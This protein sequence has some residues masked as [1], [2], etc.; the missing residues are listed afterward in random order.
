MKGLKENVSLSPFT[1]FKIGGKARYFFSAKN[2]EDIIKAVKTATA[3]KMP[4][5]VLGGGSN[6]LV[7]DKGFNG[8]VIHIENK[9]YSINDNKLYAEAGV[10]FP[11]LVSKT[12]SK[13][14]SGLEWAGGLPGTIGGAIRGNAGAFGGE[15]KDS[16]I[17]VEVLDNKR[18]VMKLKNKECKFSYRSSIFKEKNWI[19]I[20][21]VF[22]LKKGNKERILKE[23]KEHIKYRKDRHPLEYPN[24]GSIF[25]NYDAK[26]IPNRY[27]KELQHVIKRDPFDVIPTAYLIS[28][29]DLKGSRW[30]DAEVSKKHPNYIVNK[31]KAKAKDVKA[32]ISKVKKKIKEKY[33]IDL[34]QEVTI[35]E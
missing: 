27:R 17:E 22:K 23:A 21:A 33:S 24:A 4:F 6:L 29:A 16:V 30:H 1:T 19:V 11:V 15:I 31:G 28:Q 8:L 35:L 3:L 2:K 9:G 26:K 13:G 25:K 32:L 5:F 18:V 14:L 7:S 10:D 34:E 20:S 12:G